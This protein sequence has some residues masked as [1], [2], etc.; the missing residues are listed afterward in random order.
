MF[1]PVSVCLSVC[2]LTGLLK[3]KLLIES[4]LNFTEWLEIIQGPI[5]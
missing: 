5:D 3:K 1:S 2:L 4:L